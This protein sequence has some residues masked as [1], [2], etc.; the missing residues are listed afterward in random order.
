MRARDLTSDAPVVVAGDTP[1]VESTGP[2]FSIRTASGVSARMS[3]QRRRDTAPE[4]SL[5][6][7]LHAAGYRYR[8][9]YPVPGMARRTFDVAFTR[10]R[11]A[12]FI[13]GCF[14]HGCPVHGTVPTS[15]GEWW[16]A[17]IERNQGR[18][19]ETTMHL[20]DLGWSVLRVWEHDLGADGCGVQLVRRFVGLRR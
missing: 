2:N 5:R 15:N 7:A 19:G 16:C 8:V 14:W 20:Q 18:D 1:S 11:K 3:R 9:T 4:L 13:D 10:Q 17:K 6:R 12:V